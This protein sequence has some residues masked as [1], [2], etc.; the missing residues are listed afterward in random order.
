MDKITDNI[1]LGNIEAANN[2]NLLKR[3][4]YIIRKNV[5]F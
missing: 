3:N 4:V 5:T 1:F 2:K